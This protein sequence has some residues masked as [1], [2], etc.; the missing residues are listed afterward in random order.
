M[1]DEY[2]QF[3]KKIEY[4]ESDL[5]LFLQYDNW[6]EV[7]GLLLLSGLSP[8]KS[9][10]LPEKTP[11]DSIIKENL[12]APNF[13]IRVLHPL[14]AGEAFG[15]IF[16]WWILRMGAD[17]LH[18][19]LDDTISDPVAQDVQDILELAREEIKDGDM[20]K[21]ASK[22][23]SD[24][25]G[26]ML[27]EPIN[28]KQARQIFETVKTIH[29]KYER[30]FRDLCSIWY[31]GDHLDREKD[32]YPVKDF[33]IWAERKKIDVPWLEW[34]KKRGHIEKEEPPAQK[35]TEMEL[36]PVER[37]TSKIY[38][39]RKVKVI[40]D[41]DLAE[42][43]QVETKVLKRS[44]RRNI[45]RFPS[46]FMFELSK[47]ELEILRRQIDASSW[48]GTRYAP[49]AFTEQGIAMLSSVLRSKR[50]IQVNIQIMRAFTKIRHMLSGYE[51][52]KRKIEAMEKRYDRNF[53]IVFDAIKQMI[54]SESTP[55]R[56]IGF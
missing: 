10:I 35:D 22:L 41:R 31:S 2:G 7:D 19:L 13:Q 12:K 48:G 42:L 9:K 27:P 50:A 8:K 4:D 36:I 29:E 55:K 37:I 40:L 47:E 28:D 56:K 3:I 24:A 1:A 54:E 45:D 17:K 14:D 52:L 20:E 30:K 33:I 6:S 46:D 11:P 26:G 32:R 34:A 25:I 44:V 5:P 21:S 16:Q 49:M 53:Q 51:K 15:K 39:I 38:R 18:E 43:Y 23:L